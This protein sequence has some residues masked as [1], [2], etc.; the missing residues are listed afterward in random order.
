SIFGRVE[1]SYDN[2]YLLSGTLR[3]D[4]SSK[5]TNNRYGW[6]PSVSA[7]WRITEEPF[8]EEIEWL[9][10]IRIRGAYGIMG[11]QLNV[12]AGNSYTLFSG[13]EIASYYD[14]KGTSSEIV[15]GFMKQRIGNPDAR[16]E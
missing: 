9:T 2:K 13:S 3:R 16:W 4:G 1:Y 12:A 5:F 11:N 15:Q 7:G 6:F 8:M 14:I 10:D